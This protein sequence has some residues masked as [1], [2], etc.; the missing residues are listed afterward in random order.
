LP[1]QAKVRSTF[2]RRLYR[3]N[4]RPSCVLRFRRFRR[5]GQISSMPRRFS[6]FR[7]G[8]LSYPLSA[9]TRSGFFRGR[10][11]L[12]RGT[13]TR[14]SVF[15]RS[16]TSAGL[17]ESRWFPR[18][19]PWPSTTTIHFVPLPRL[20]GPTQAPLFSPGR[21]SRRRRPRTSRVGLSG[22]IRPEK[23]ARPLTRHLPPPT[24]SA[25][26]STCLAMGTLPGGPSTGPQSATPRGC[27]RAPVGAR[28]VCDRPYV[29]ASASVRAA[30]SSPT[31][32]R[33]ATGT[34]PSLLLSMASGI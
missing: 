15:S 5:C 22:P 7:R 23:P 8:S 20:V 2:Q 28:S 16:V 9:M 33:S 19:T 6:R 26:A 18:G 30:R 31:A 4:L 12:F 24:V 11:R 3:R 34:W 17:A 10:P 25:A 13:A 1:N 32:R 14:S 27:L 21:T 29:T